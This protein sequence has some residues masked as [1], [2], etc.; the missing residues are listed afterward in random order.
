MT[1]EYPPAD[2]ILFRK[3]RQRTAKGSPG[4]FPFISIAHSSPD[5]QSYENKGQKEYKSSNQSHDES[6]KTYSSDQPK[7]SSSSK[8]KEIS[9]YVKVFFHIR[10]MIW[11]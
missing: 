5:A 2:P 9:F 1:G 6:A 7:D 8:L 3:N 4:N 11:S 10:F